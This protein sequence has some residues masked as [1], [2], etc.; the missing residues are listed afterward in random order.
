MTPDFAWKIMLQLMPT[1]L[2]AGYYL[3][4]ILFHNFNVK[5]REIFTF[6]FWKNLVYSVRVWL[7]LLGGIL[8]L[9]WSYHNLCNFLE[10]NL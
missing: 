10:A 5:W 9:Y 3:F 1:M 4:S 8:F 7:E 2:L 6:A